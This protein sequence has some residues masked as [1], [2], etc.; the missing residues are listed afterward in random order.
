MIDVV[1][2]SPEWFEI[3]RGKVT[4]SAIHKVMAR[5]K[6]GP[7]ADRTN[8]MMQLVVER[9]TGKVAESY[10]SAAM[11]EGKDREPLARAAY[12]FQHDVTV[13]LVGFVP[14][15]MIEQA[16]CSPDG[17]VGDQGLI[18]IKCPQ[19][20]AHFDTLINGIPSRYEDQMQM[21]MACTGRSWVDYCSYN[22]DFPQASKLYVMRY[23][24]EESRIRAIEKEIAAFLHEMA[25]KLAQYNAIYDTIAAA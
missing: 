22:P 18:E 16:G 23:F 13:E 15:P 14:H 21:Q 24:R 6:S 2:G 12:E 7:S 5:T 11:Q 8:Y 1:Q 4:A 25:Y 3:R 9:L 17:L 10:V 20:A 19:Q